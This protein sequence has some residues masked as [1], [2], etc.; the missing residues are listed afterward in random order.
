MK[1]ILVALFVLGLCSAS[2]L[3]YG[4][5]KLSGF[6]EIQ[7]VTPDLHP[8]LIIDGGLNY[9][10]TDQWG[11]RAFFLEKGGWAEAYVGPTWTP[12]RYLTLFAGAGVSQKK[13]LFE[14]RTA[15]SASFFYEGLGASAAVEMNNPAYQGDYKSIWYDLNLT[16]Q[17]LPWLVVGVKDRRPVGFGPQIRFKYDVFE[18]WTCWAPVNAEDT[19]TDWKRFILALKFNL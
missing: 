10:I 4:Q 14:L 15:Y 7:S 12:V 11:A 17:P 2:S 18:F 13:G 5:R 1:R 3:A 6:V 19:G 9:Q 8:N 16:Y